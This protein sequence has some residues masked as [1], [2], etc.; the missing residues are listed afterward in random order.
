M[1]KMRLGLRKM[2]FLMVRPSPRLNSPS[3]FWEQAQRTVPMN[4][5]DE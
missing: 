5:A 1:G 2:L 3:R 4:K